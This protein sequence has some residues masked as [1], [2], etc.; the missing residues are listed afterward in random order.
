MFRKV[1]MGDCNVSIIISNKDSDS[2][3]TEDNINEVPLTVA[4]LSWANQVMKNKKL[5]QSHPIK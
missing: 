2:F 1:L 4:V 5:S 3:Y